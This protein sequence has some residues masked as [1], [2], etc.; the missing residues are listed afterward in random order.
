MYDTLRF[1]NVMT[2]VLAILGKSF[3]W[4]ILDLSGLVSMLSQQG[5]HVHLFIIRLDILVSRNRVRTAML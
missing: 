1:T 3:G 2:G 4:H 5:L